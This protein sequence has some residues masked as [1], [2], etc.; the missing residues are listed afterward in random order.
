MRGLA[1][2]LLLLAAGCASTYERTDFCDACL[3]VRHLAGRRLLQSQ[4]LSD[5]AGS[6]L[7]AGLHRHDWRVTHEQTDE[8]IYC[9]MAG[10]PNALCRNLESSAE[11]RDALRDRIR[12]G[13]ISAAEL[14][15]A[16]HV[17]DDR[18]GKLPE[19]ERTTYLRVLTVA[20]SCPGWAAEDPSFMGHRSR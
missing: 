19:L 15:R 3:S 6:D 5:L 8:R 1:L 12:E 17:R 10:G 20:T 9:N 14:E 2:V 7:L 18:L 4:R 16:L 11:L 13:A